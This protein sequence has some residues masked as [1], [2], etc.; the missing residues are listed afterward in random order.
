[1]RPLL[2]R[3]I[4]ST[5]LLIAVLGLLPA[6][7]AEG[8]AARSGQPFFVSGLGFDTCETPTVETMQAWRESPYKV[9]GIY[10][11]G[12]N[13]ACESTRLTRDWVTAVH[14]QGWDFL[15]I[16]VG[17]QAPCSQARKPDR[18]DPAQAARQGVAEA[19]D[20]V[21]RSTALGFRRG[22]AVWFDMEAYDN[23]DA[24]CRTA[25]L[26]FV[27]AW[28]D[29]VRERGFVAGYYSS[30][31]SGVADLVQAVGSR[32]IPDA[33]WYA[34]WDDKA[35]TS[36]DGALPD[37]HWHGNRVHQYSGNVTETY[38]GRTLSVDRNAV[39]GPVGVF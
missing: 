6:G 13:R 2:T 29:R 23:T 36:G 39:D 18:I 15:P 12:D 33:I 9:V 30:L 26:D 7:L 35:V 22:S 14:D 19:D 24:A 38:G 1:M 10:V 11:A 16:Q 34:R 28:S 4:A 37:G 21:D 31:D 3:R 27:S 8:A 17:P 25:V 32:S 20:M 5:V